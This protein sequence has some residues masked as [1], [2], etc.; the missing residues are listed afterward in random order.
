MSLKSLL[1]FPE[2][3]ATLREDLFRVSTFEIHTIDIIITLNKPCILILKSTYIKTTCENT[4]FLNDF[5]GHIK[6]R[7]W[8]CS[9]KKVSIRGL[10]IKTKS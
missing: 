10:T 5:L 2:I 7:R 8:G 6:F 4:L 3:T 1:I 9:N